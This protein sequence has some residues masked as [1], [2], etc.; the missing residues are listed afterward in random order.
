[1]LGCVGEGMWQIAEAVNSSQSFH[2]IEGLEPGTLYTVRLMS[3]RLFNNASIY[4]D[5]FQTQGQGEGQPF[6]PIL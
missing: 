1:M 2:L 6:V 5:V 4:E 3:K